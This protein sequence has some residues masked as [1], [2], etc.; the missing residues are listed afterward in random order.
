MK[1]HIKVVETCNIQ[2]VKLLKNSI[3]KSLFIRMLFKGIN[4]F[5]YVITILG[6]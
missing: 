4:L 3:K 6:E 2:S 1:E 5:I